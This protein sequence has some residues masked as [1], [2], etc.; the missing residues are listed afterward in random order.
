VVEQIHLTIIGYCYSKVA[1][2]SDTVDPV[3]FKSDFM[4]CFFLFL[5]FLFFCFFYQEC[6]IRVLQLDSVS[7]QLG[8]TLL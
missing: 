1:L 6:Y 7:S 5:F 4:N 2:S 3:F 8:R